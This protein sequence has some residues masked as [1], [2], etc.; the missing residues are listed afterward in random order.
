MGPWADSSSPWMFG[1]F[2]T[3]MNRMFEP[4][5][6]ERQRH[7]FPALTIIAGA[8]EATVS[9]LVPGVGV[10]DLDIRVLGDT[11]RISGKRTLPDIHGVWHRRERFSGDFSRTFRLPF[12][13][14]AEAVKSSLKDGVLTLELS[15]PAADRPRRITVQSH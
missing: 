4:A 14:D 3:V 6:Q 9:A 15:R 10:E 11:V 7:V 1:P 5:P 2:E 13:V 8:D 12:R